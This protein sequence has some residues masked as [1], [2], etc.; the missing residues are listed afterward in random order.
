MRQMVAILYLALSQVLVVVVGHLIH[1][2]MAAL[3]VLVA[4]V[5]QML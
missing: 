4:V 3:A 1:Q 5:R 2:A